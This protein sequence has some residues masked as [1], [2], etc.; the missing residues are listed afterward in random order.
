LVRVGALQLS[1]ACCTEKLLKSSNENFLFHPHSLACR[2]PTNWTNFFKK[3]EDKI[4]KRIKEK[5]RR[6]TNKR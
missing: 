3:I 2:Y 5:K 1:E 6:K 4:N